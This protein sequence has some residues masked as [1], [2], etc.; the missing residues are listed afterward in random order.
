MAAENSPPAAARVQPSGLPRKTIFP[1]KSGCESPV[2]WQRSKPAGC[3]WSALSRWIAAEAKRSSLLG[4]FAS[5]IIPNG[6]DT[7]DF[8][9]RDKMFS[10]DTLGVPR[11]KKVVLFVADS[12]T[13]K[14]K[15]FDYLAKALEGLR[16]RSDLFLLSVGGS[17]PKISGLPILHL[18]R[19]N[20]DRMLSIIYSAADV[21][22]IPS[23]QES[24]GQTVTES[25]ACGTPVVGFDT[26]GIPDMVRPGITGYLA[27]VGNASELGSAIVRVLD[28][29]DNSAEMS[30]NCRQI[31]EQEYSMQTQA[32][33][34]RAFYQTLLSKP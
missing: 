21:F 4:R 18:G 20:H 12:A 25:L 10:R 34:Y 1:G 11:D 6:L 7:S 19:I 8:A 17:E 28:A 29:P 22:V 9:P 32:Q 33:A 16:D 31:A 30:K 23:L 15:G 27:P 3:T 2:R 13:N 26:G 24:F 14:R 5:T